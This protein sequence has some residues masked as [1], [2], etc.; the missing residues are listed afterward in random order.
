MRKELQVC[1]RA[2]DEVRRSLTMER[3]IIPFAE[4]LL[5]ASLP[6][7][8][9]ETRLQWLIAGLRVMEAMRLYAADHDGRWPD[10]LSDITEVPLPLNPYDG[11]PFVYERHGDKA[12]LTV[13]HGPRASIG[14]TRSR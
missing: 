13:E 8:Q 9:A 14:A 10:R 2:A 4:V 12:L 5:P 11:K 3:E 1:D 7:K 6:A